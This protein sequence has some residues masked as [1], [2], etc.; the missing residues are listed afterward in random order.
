MSALGSQDGRFVAFHGASTDN[1]PTRKW[2]RQSTIPDRRVPNFLPSYFGF[3]FHFSR[4]T[5][6]I[7][8][9]YW[10]PI[11]VS[12]MFAWIPKTHL[13]NR[14]S[15]HTLLIVTTLI[16]VVLGMIVWAVRAG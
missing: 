1:P 15:L 5:K 4:G 3:Y 12:I 9:P 7:W 8:V 10:F 2:H 13:P 6:L 14:F 16:A 11:L